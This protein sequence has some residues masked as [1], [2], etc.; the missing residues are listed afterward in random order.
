MSNKKDFL[1]SDIENFQLIKR[2]WKNIQAKRKKQ[3]SLLLI[4]MTISGFLEI[5]SLAAIIPF[6]GVIT[7]PDRLLQ[8]S[9]VRE[10]CFYAIFQGFN[11]R[12]RY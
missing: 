7:N 9:W 10:I 5:V 11:W 2:L 1:L 4:L 8:K 3:L 12:N 6:I